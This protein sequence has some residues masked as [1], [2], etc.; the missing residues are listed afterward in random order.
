MPESVREEVTKHLEERRTNVLAG[1]G[2][3]SSLTSQLPQSDPRHPLRSFEKRMP[4]LCLSAARSLMRH[5]P[6]DGSAWSHDRAL[7]SLCT[8]TC[9]PRSDKR[10]CLPRRRQNRV[11]MCHCHLT[12]IAP[13]PPSVDEAKKVG[14]I[15]MF[16]C[17]PPHE[18][19]LGPHTVL[20]YFI[21]TAYANYEGGAS[22]EE[23]RRP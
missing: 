14:R 15:R 17:G 8:R 21:I 10:G 22:Q 9:T 6:R 13:P 18:I 16:T 23:C 19:F 1:V 7:A 20:Y 3:G 4:R 11:F 2:A 5:C 12:V